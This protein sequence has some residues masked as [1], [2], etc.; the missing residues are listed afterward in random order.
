CAKHYDDIFAK[1]A[2]IVEAAGLSFATYHQKTPL[3]SLFANAPEAVELHKSA[4]EELRER[5]LKPVFDS[6]AR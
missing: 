6:I 4:V 1:T 5:L 3:F 2:N